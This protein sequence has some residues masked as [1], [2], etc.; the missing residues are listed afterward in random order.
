MCG[1]FSF[2]YTQRYGLGGKVT[3]RQRHDVCGGLLFVKKFML[4]ALPP[5]RCIAL[6]PTLNGEPARL[7]LARLIL[8]RCHRLLPLVF[9]YGARDLCKYRQAMP[10]LI[11]G[12]ISRTLIRL[13]QTVATYRAAV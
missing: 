6:Q 1:T 12:W 9:H 5:T 3:L 8:K 11:A 13:F 10:S 4:G 2:S 7:P